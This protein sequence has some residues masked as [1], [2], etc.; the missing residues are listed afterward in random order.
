MTTSC[1]TGNTTTDFHA[2]LVGHGARLVHNVRKLHPLMALLGDC[3]GAPR[4]SCGL[5]GRGE[6]A[7]ALL[8]L[9]E[10]FTLTS[11]VAGLLELPCWL[12]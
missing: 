12:G 6:L 5:V 11:I 10:F 9:L 7:R 8:A 4:A 2:L 3:V 1:M